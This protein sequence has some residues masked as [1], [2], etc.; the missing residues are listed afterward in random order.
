M[1]VGGMGGGDSGSRRGDEATSGVGNGVEATK[2]AMSM[3]GG[4]VGSRPR[5]FAVG[6]AAVTG[7]VVWLPTGVSG[8]AGASVSLTSAKTWMETARRRAAAR[9]RGFTVGSFAVDQGSVMHPSAMHNPCHNCDL[10]GWKTSSLPRCREPRRQQA[11]PPRPG[12]GGGVALGRRLANGR[13]QDVHL[14]A[15]FGHGAAGDA[16]AVV[17]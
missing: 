11:A 2:A 17:E 6:R 15:V 13:G 4:A 10:M 3:S 7:A 12:Y 14:A 5:G 16:N 9:K 8:A 1:A